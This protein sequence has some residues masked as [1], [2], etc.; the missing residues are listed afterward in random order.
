ML[1]IGRLHISTELVGGFEEA[2]FNAEV[3]AVVY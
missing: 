3:R 2:G 1:V